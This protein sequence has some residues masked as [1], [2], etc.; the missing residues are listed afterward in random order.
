[1]RPANSASPTPIAGQERLHLIDALRGFALA[2]VLMVNLAT[3]TLYEFLDDAA[4]AA[5]PTAAFDRIALTFMHLFVDNKAITLFSLLFGLGFSLQMERAAARGGDGLR[6]YLR[7]LGVLALIGAL[8][9]YLLWWGDILLIY[10]LVASLL[11]PF[12][13]ASDR[14]LLG[15]GLFVALAL[16]P[17]LAPWLEP[18]L[19][20]LPSDRT[21]AAANLAAFSSPSFAA[22]LRQNV[23]FGNYAWA[24]YWGVYCFVAG[25]FLLGYWAGRRRLLQQPAAHRRLLRGLCIGGLLIGGAV[26]CV[27]E[28]TD[29]VSAA[30]ALSGAGGAIVRFALRVLGRCGPLALGIGYAAAF[31]LLWLRPRWQRM[32]GLLAPV[33]RMALSNYLMQT[34]VCLGVFYGYGLGVGPR[35]GLVGWLGMWAMLYGTQ[36]ALSRWWLARFRFGPME[37]LWR[38]LTYA[39]PQPMRLDATQ[40]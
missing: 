20:A 17:L 23:A 37:W 27:F 29:P 39:R 19:A 11:V 35:L 33:G 34:I 25:R 31:A 4:R 6:L 30:E 28:Y 40:R 13:H 32:L 16:P 10:A 5:L 12:R 15:A 1:M 2:G 7:R 9:A 21:M 22:V 3:F 14:V 36:I 38:S 24:A 18:L 26:T 8:H